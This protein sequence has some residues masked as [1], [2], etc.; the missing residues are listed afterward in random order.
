MYKLII[1]IN[2]V[3]V[4]IRKEIMR[5]SISHKKIDLNGLE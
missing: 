5:F 1:Y 3:S 4:C 2:F